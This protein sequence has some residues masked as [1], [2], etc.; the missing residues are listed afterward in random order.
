MHDDVIVYLCI[1]STLV[2]REDFTVS[3][4]HSYIIGEP[5]QYYYQDPEIPITA[6][7]WGKG[8]QQG[9]EEEIDREFLNPVSINDVFN[10]FGSGAIELICFFRQSPAQIIGSLSLNMKGFYRILLLQYYIIF[11]TINPH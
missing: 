6:I 8:I 1:I 7:R 4:P 2:R 3:K 11:T 5:L 9:D 10:R